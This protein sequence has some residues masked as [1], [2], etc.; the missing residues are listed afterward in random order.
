MAYCVYYGLVTV[1]VGLFVNCIPIGFYV[2][3]IT[4][5]FVVLFT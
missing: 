4:D 3:S 1:S 2:Y 5:A